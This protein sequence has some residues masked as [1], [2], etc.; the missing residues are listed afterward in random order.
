M[1]INCHAYQITERLFLFFFYLF[2]NRIQIHSTCF[3]FNSKFV[4]KLIFY[5]LRHLKW[6]IFKIQIKNDEAK[7]EN[8]KN[9]QKK[10]YEN[11]QDLN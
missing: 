11:C 9:K 8:D 2:A 4:Q 5:S 6:K 3:L 10:I 1:L 7:E